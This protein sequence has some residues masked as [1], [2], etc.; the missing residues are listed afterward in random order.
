MGTFLDVQ[1]RIKSLPPEMPRNFPYD[2]YPRSQFHVVMFLEMSLSPS[3]V[4]FQQS[5]CS[6]NTESFFG[7]TA[8]QISNK[9]RKGLTRTGL[10]HSFPIPFSSLGTN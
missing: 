3:N 8:I 7:T 1:L 10:L 2:E 6:I 9:M 5:T 4:T